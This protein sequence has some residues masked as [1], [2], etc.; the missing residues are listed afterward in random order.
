MVVLAAAHS[1]SRRIAAHQIACVLQR[2]HGVSTG[3][4]SSVSLSRKATQIFVCLRC[5]SAG[6]ANFH[7][8]NDALDSLRLLSRARILAHVLEAQQLP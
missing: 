7:S 2:R 5:L 4:A 8:Q 3:L 1:H 6:D